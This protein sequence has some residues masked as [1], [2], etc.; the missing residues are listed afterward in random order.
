M[1][2]NTMK[3]KPLF[4]LG[5]TFFTMLAS[6]AY[7]IEMNQLPLLPSVSEMAY[8]N[9]LS[10][11][12][13]DIKSVM[14]N[15]S[16]P[17]AGEP[18]KV[19]AVIFE[20][21]DKTDLT[22]DHATAHLSVDGGKTWQDIPMAQS[23]DNPSLWTAEFP[24]LEKDVTGIYYVSCEDI[25]GNVATEMP[26]QVTQWPP[27][28]T[29][30]LAPTGTDP[31]EKDDVV[32]SSMDILKSFMGYDE[33]YLYFKIEYEKN[34]KPGT[35]SPPFLHS[36]G[37]AFWNRDKS[38]DILATYMLSYMPLLKIGGL[39][40]TTLY[41]ANRIA[42][43]YTVGEESKIEDNVLYLRV[44]R[45][46]IG[47]NPTGRLR[48]AYN[49]FAVNTTRITE[50]IGFGDVTDPVQIFREKI[51]SQNVGW[52]QFVDTTLKYF[53][54][55]QVVILK[56]IDVVRQFVTFQDLSPYAY[57]YLRT[58]DFTVK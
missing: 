42:Y 48:V 15:P 54:R 35:S 6:A 58:H 38:T 31:D 20:D 24:P 49:T 40:E 2:N 51:N 3:T 37:A 8:N 13:P 57:V 17:V 41:D 36:Y 22:V 11:T 21:T 18:A 55:N 32:A 19:E 23:E 50:Q 14:L 5:F 9:Y 53:R 45:S 1:R 12:P 44:K 43:D 25:E 30:E 26:R 34:I 16:S 4:L 52:V 46:V 7:A 29:T 39:P 47:N 28:D 10:D 33:Q 56:D 27:S